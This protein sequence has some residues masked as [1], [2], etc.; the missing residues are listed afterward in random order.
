M[1]MSIKPIINGV[2]NS[3]VNRTGINSGL[4]DLGA[5]FQSASNLPAAKTI[6]EG[7]V[8]KRLVSLACVSIGFHI[9]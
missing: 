2:K 8:K 3:S 5:I 6:N 7:S 9:G 1:S 4:N